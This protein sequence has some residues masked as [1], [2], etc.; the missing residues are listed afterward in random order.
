MQHSSGT[1]SSIT[2]E[3]VHRDL[4]FSNR[5]RLELIKHMMTISAALLAFTVSFRPS[6]DYIVFPQAM[7][8]GWGGLVVSLFGGVSTMHFWAEFY[9]SYRDCDWKHR[10]GNGSISG[11]IMRRKITICRHISVY[12]QY[13]GFFVGVL[14][15]GLFAALNIDNIK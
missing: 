6:L 7:W 15:V 1:N 10:S 9:K 8:L 2:I 12:L 11:V 14:F 4:D 3:S 13:G 5:Y